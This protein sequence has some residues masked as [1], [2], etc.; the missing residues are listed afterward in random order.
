MVSLGLEF[1][2]W[3]FLQLR[4]G[5]QQNLADNPGVGSEDPLIT[6]GVGIWIGMNIDVAVVASDNSVGGFVQTGFKF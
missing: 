3:D 2:A 1:N 5:M 4:L 6:A